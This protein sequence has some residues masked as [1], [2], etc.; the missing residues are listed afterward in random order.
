MEGK[1][2]DIEI[3]IPV[4]KKIDKTEKFTFKERLLISNALVAV[5]KGNPNKIQKTFYELNQYILQRGLN[6]IT[7]GYNVTR[8]I[9]LKNQDDSEIYVYVGINPNII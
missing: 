8:K 1:L 7:V 5:H 3:R 4:D 9:E 2:I 6:P